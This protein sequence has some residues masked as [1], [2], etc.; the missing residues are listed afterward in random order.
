MN[1]T[2]FDEWVLLPENYDYT[3][4]LIDGKP[5]IKH[6]TNPYDSMIGT[7][8]LG[9]IGMYLIQKNDIGYLT[10][11]NGGYCV[12]DERYVPDGALVL[13]TRQKLP[14]KTAYNS[15]PPNLAIEVI[16]AE[17]TIEELRLLMSKITNYHG[18]GCA[19]WVVDTERNCI[20]VYEQSKLVHIL[21]ITDILTAPTLLPNFTLPLQHIFVTTTND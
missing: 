2:E 3:F 4:E 6:P 9:F 10:S 17:T 15:V 5:I 7:R 16:S 18:V 1:S 11:A 20:D 8:I 21:G 12:G 14:D 13:Y 19:V